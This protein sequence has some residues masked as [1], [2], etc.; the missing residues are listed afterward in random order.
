MNSPHNTPTQPAPRRPRNGIGWAGLWLIL[1]ESRLI[2]VI[3]IVGLLFLLS[4]V[5]WMLQNLAYPSYLLI[6]SLD[7]ATGAAALPGAP[8][9]MWAL[10]GGVFGAAL[11]NWLLAP[12]YGGRELRAMP[13]LLLVLAMLLVGA[14][15][16][17]F[18]R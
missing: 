18:V 5:L 9:V 7:A 4:A 16:W 13:L 11:G 12:L 8:W 15:L 10:W 6:R 3:G 1:V 17:A 14:L 2:F